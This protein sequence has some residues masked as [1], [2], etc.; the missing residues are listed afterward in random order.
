MMTHEWF[1][2]LLCKFISNDGMSNQK[3][4]DSVF[5]DLEYVHRLRLSFICSYG[6][7]QLRNAFSQLSK[8]DS[9]YF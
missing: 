7:Y 4:H 1:L 2:V 9:K 5:L 8:S 6:S 3:N